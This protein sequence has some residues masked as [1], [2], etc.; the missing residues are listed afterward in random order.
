MFWRWFEDCRKNTILHHTWCRRR[1][2]D[3]TFMPRI[4]GASKRRED[5][6]ERL[7]SKEYENR[8]CLGRKGLSPSRSLWYWN[9]G[10]TASWIRIVNGIEKLCN[11]S[12]RNHSYW[13]RWA[14]SYRE[15]CCESKLFYF[16]SWKKW[17]DIDPE[18]SVK[19]VS[20]CQKPW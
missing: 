16:C 2:T 7:D 14:R 5:S 13:K 4:H 12:D 10:R 9:S 17:M 19:I 20:H 8:P 3:A 11:W 6:S 1:T 15:T 18:R